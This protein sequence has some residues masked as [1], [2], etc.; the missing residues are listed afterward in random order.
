MAIASSGSAPAGAARSFVSPAAAAPA[1][2]AVSVA[3][4]AAPPAPITPPNLM[5]S[6]AGPTTPPAI[7]K[8]ADKTVEKKPRTKRTSARK[9]PKGVWDPKALLPPK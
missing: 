3:E 9:P 1:P 6:A 7:A 4:P 2:A 8:I 5:P